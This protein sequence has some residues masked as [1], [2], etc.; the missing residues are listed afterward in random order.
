MSRRRPSTPARF[1]MDQ[2]LIRGKILDYGCGRGRD[3]AWYEEL[4]F[5]AAG[6][7]ENPKGRFADEAPL[8]HT[9]DTILAVY[10]LNVNPPSEWPGIV[11]RVRA[12]LRKDGIAYFA[13]RRDL[14]KSG[15]GVQTYVELELPIVKS[16]R[17]KGFVIYRLDGDAK[18]IR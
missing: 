12:L 14:P 13:V 17:R 7:D 3:V 4:G 18:P 9:Y 15:R 6:Y 10:V 11:E 2:G 1:L 5:E 8:R 16:K